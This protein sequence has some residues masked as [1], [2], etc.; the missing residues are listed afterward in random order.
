[1]LAGG[2]VWLVF[3]LAVRA[4][5]RELDRAGQTARGKV[6]PVDPMERGL[7][8]G[9]GQPVM[10]TYRDAHGD[11]HHVTDESG[12]GG[13][14]VRAGT[15]AVVR[16]CPSRPQLV[17]VEQLVG[18]SGP[19]PV[20]PDGL[21]RRSLLAPLFPLVVGGLAAVF[22]GRELWRD[23]DQPPP[24][25]VDLAL[26]L[27][28]WGL[29]L[30]VAGLLLAAIVSNIKRRAR[31]QD[32]RHWAETVGEVTDVWGRSYPDSLPHYLFTVRFAA[33][34]GEAWVSGCASGATGPPPAAARA[35]PPQPRRKAGAAARSR[36]RR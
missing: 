25:V 9:A 23:S 2:A 31:S 14:L 27:L 26:L 28:T 17:R 18:R 4:D 35:G 1:M 24:A 10:L 19:Y 3:R 32:S 11:Q 15:P 13:Y 33:R 29:G 22:V 16:Y 36:Q 7:N 5:D 30:A 21:R 12:L 6:T 8:N 20:W 34:D